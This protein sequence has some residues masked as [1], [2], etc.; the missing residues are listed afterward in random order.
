MPVQSFAPR[1][2]LGLAQHS[3]EFG[4]LQFGSTGLFESSLD[5]WV[6]LVRFQP[7]IEIH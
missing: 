7:E 4:A 1:L 6:C 2:V 3:R 5:D